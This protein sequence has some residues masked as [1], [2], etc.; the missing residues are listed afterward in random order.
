MRHTYLPNATRAFVPAHCQDWGHRSLL[1]RGRKFFNLTQLQ[2]YFPLTVVV[3]E[4]SAVEL[5]SNCCH[6]DAPRGDL[7]L[8][9]FR[10][11]DSLLRSKPFRIMH[12]E[13]QGVRSHAN[14]GCMS[15][16]S[17]PSREIGR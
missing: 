13:D 9:Q 2:L 5:L 7:S 14:S 3:W 16:E 12:L 4:D 1:P 6:F 17:W 11:R 10:I 15:E 8:K